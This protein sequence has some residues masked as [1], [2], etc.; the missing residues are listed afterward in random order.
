MGELDLNNESIGRDADGP[1][2]TTISKIRNAKLESISPA[3][4]RKLDA[5]LQWHKGSARRVAL[6]GDPVVATHTV[7]GV[8]DRV[9]EIERSNLSAATKQWLIAQLVPTSIA[10]EAGEGA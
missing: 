1:S 7:L 10:T 3:T 4:Y 2:T 6:G 5:A 8:A 9:A